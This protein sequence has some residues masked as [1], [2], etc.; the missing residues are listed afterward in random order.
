MAVHDHKIMSYDV[1]FATDN[2]VIH[3]E[4]GDDGG[5]KICDVAFNGYFTHKF[6]DAA[7]NS[8]IFE[9]EKYDIPAF[10]EDHQLMLEEKRKYRW[11]IKYETEEELMRYLSDGE[12]YYY[13]LSSISG[14][15]GWVLA[16][17]MTIA[18]LADE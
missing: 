13:V 6:N 12:Y 1:N 4:Y 8:I 3:T 11:P 15:Y 14:L 5:Y 10:I 17:E 7:K 16:K 18:E 2:L 9:I